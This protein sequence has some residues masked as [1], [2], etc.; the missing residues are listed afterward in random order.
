M[1]KTGCVVFQGNRIPSASLL[2]RSS[3]VRESTAQLEDILRRQWSCAS[4]ERQKADSLPSLLSFPGR[5]RADSKRSAPRPTLSG[6]RPRQATSLWR[7]SPLCVDCGVGVSRCGS[8]IKMKIDMDRY[9]RE[10]QILLQM[11]LPFLNKLQFVQCFTSKNEF[12]ISESQCIYR[13]NCVI[14]R[15]RNFECFTAILLKG[16]LGLKAINVGRHRYKWST[17]LSAC[18]SKQW[19]ITSQ[20]I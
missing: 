16:P 6:R 2:P 4:V 15:L 8:L 20:C 5:S 13:Q 7:V 3:S 1:S 9:F 11:V 12:R 17:S 18:E 10:L 14:K 19:S